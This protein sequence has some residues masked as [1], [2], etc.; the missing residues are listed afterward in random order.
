MLPAMTARLCRFGVVF[1]LLWPGFRAAANSPL[2]LAAGRQT[3]VRPTESRQTG[4]LKVGAGQFIHLAFD[5]RDLDIAVTVHSPALGKL[6]EAD[7]FEYGKDSISIVAKVDEVVEVRVRVLGRHSPDAFY[8][9]TVDSPREPSSADQLRIEAES[10]STAVKQSLV[11]PSPGTLPKILDDSRRATSLWRRVGDHT[12]EAGSL[13]QTGNILYIQGNLAAARDQYL[14]AL[15]QSAEYRD[16]QNTAESANDA[17]YCEMQLGELKQSEKHLEEARRTWVELKSRYG[18][19]TALNNIG[20]WNWQ[21]ADFGAARQSYQQAFRFTDFRDPKARALVLNNIGLADLSL[22]DYP[23]AIDSLSRAV[24]LFPTEDR[25]ARGRALMN[26]GRAY[27]LRGNWSEA[28]RLCNQALPLVQVSP[29]S[30]AV[31]DVLNNLG[32][33][34]AAG[35]DTSKVQEYIR[36]AQKVYLR[37]GD[38]RGQ[39]SATHHLGLA[40]WASGDSKQA[41]ELLQQASKIREE[42][43][44]RDDLADTL[45]ALARVHRDLGEPELARRDAERSVQL[46]ESL[47]TT[48]PGEQLRVAYFAEKQPL[49]EFYVDLLMQMHGKHLSAGF[50]RI[51][52]EVSE[53]ARAR[54]LLE[55]LGRA[56]TQI[57]RGIDP[58][59][60]ATERRAHQILNFKSQQMSRLLSSVHPPEREAALRKELDSAREANQRIELEIRQK[61]PEYANLV[62]PQPKRLVEIQHHVIDQDTL[63]LEYCLGDERSYLWAVTPEDVASFTLPRRGYLEGLAKTVVRLAGDYRLRMRDP[64][65]ARQYR[66]AVK[67]LGAALLKPVAGKIGTKRILIVASGILQRV[68]FAALYVP[69]DSDPDAAPLGVRNELVTMPSA[70]TLAELRETQGGRARPHLSVAVLADPVFDSQDPRVLQKREKGSTATQGPAGLALSRLAFTREEAARILAPMPAGGSLA[71]LGFDASRTTLMQPKIGGYRFLHIA[72]HYLL[73]AVHPELSGLVLSLVDRQG[74]P[75]SGVIRLDDLYNDLPRLSCDLV[76]LSACNSGLGKDMHGEGMIALTRAFLYAG[77]SRV[78]VSLWTC[79]DQAA[80]ELM[81]L[82]YQAMLAGSGRSPAAALRAARETFWKRGERWRDPYFS[83]GLALYGEYR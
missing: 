67:A 3:V 14:A 10:L 42:L 6:A 41:L 1:A 63:L 45:F 4:K 25:L 50:D 5:Q 49:Y 7:E 37:A 34:Y 59:L 64:A 71:A 19:A 69:G 57:R 11:S 76:T 56:R 60:L 70:S 30:R 32:Q 44:L 82:F 26:L 80:A 15:S 65:S 78:L 73:D 38:R 27:L 17:G 43:G 22:A 16:A 33:A 55:S 20:L 29:D 52:F 31:A 54:A 61:N 46:I 48:V 18:Q 9:I 77:S 24:T 12:A 39:A 47:R 35:Q 72:T 2:T 75:Q 8:A 53:R 21:V 81:G 74:L 28:I 40:S 23:N 83:A 79:D 62:W 36:E 66:Y 68:P 51:A 58:E 13:I